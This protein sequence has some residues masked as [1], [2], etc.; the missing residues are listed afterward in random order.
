MSFKNCIIYLSI[1]YIMNWSVNNFNFMYL[2]YI[3]MRK[4]CPQLVFFKLDT[5]DT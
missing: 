4:Q 2:R 5:I 1:Q 3:F